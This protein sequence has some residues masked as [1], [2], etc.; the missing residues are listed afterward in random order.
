MPSRLAVIISQASSRDHRAAEIEEALVGELMMTSGLDANLVGPLQRIQPESTDLLCL[1]GFTQD[2][3]LLSWLPLDEAQNAWRDLQLPGTLIEYSPSSPSPFLKVAIPD[4]GRR[5]AYLQLNPDSSPV[6]ICQLLKAKLQDMQVK[7]VSLL[8]LVPPPRPLP[9][10]PMQ[11][12]VASILLPKT[13]SPATG[14]SSYPVADEITEE[15]EWEKLDQLV[16][17]LDAL[18]L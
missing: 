12:S 7:T 6:K 9:V 3:A 13:S 15:A 14:P 5:I 18:D 2:I 11:P 10:N 4:A 8:P 17:D 1:S 16:D